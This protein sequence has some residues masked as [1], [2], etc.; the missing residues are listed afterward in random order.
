MSEFRVRAVLIICRTFKLP[1]VAITRIRALAMWV[2]PST[3]DPAALKPWT[4][5]LLDARLHA[6]H[7]Q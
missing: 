2:C 5:W 4:T 1:G 3:T 6:E 7:W